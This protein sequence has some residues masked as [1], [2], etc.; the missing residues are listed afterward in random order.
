MLEEE[1]KIEVEYTQPETSYDVSVQLATTD[2]KLIQKAC[3]DF[4]TFALTHMPEMSK[5]IKLPTEKASITTRKSPCGE[6]TNT[7][8]KYKMF[9]Y[10]RVFHFIT[11]SHT[12][13]EIARFFNNSNVDVR[14]TLKG[15]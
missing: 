11:G 10:K 9:V 14:V 15:N 4:Y 6:G 3:A 1:K 8:S 2:K 7:W 12:L 13:E 5:A